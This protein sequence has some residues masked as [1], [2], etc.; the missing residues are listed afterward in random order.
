MADALNVDL[1]R[2][3]AG[4]PTIAARL[5]VDLHGPTVLVLFGPSGSGK[6]TVLRA[7][8]G[9]D[10]PDCGYIR[11]RGQTWFDSE[12]RVAVPPQARRTGCVFQDAALFPHL[13]ARAN[14]EYGI[15]QADRE[16]RR[17]QAAEMLSLVEAVELAD[18]YPAELS[19]G[20]A[21]RVALARALAARPHLLLL[22]E[23]FAALDQP[24]QTRLRRLLRSL[25][26]AL[27]IPCV[28]VT[29][30]RTE[31]LALGDQM[32]VLAG[33]SIRQVGPVTDVFRRPADLVVAQS[34]GV[35][36]VL[37]A[38]VE[39][40]QD[41]LADLAVGPAR[42]RA[43]AEGLEPASRDVYACIRA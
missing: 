25:L 4:G 8:A 2:R 1:E 7:L 3:F 30:D 13:T 22:D 41:G 9:L 14:V 19:G 35:E 21:R 33:G 31:A 34:V 38:R 5:A 39:H 37:A 43:V 27:D 42:L 28:L 23:P 12:S 20:Q 36:S 17:S 32:A 15:A 11:F 26:N 10:H 29:H 6:T 18:R 16:A 24:A 40:V